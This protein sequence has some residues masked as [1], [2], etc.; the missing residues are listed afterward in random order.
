M[1][2]TAS[3]IGVEP[4]GTWKSSEVRI[5][6]MTAFLLKLMTLTVLAPAFATKI[7]PSALQATADG[8]LPTSSL[9]MDFRSAELRIS[10]ALSPQLAT[11]NACP[12]CDSAIA[13]GRYPTLALIASEPF[14]FVLYTLPSRMLTM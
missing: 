7:L 4:T 2:S 3:A 6:S 12:S 9:Q 13:H 14:A 1:E 5:V 8:W 11:A 10:T